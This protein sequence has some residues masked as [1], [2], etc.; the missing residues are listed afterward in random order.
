MSVG[1]SSRSYI[2]CKVNWPFCS[3]LARY[4]FFSLFNLESSKLQG[5]RVSTSEQQVTAHPKPLIMPPLSQEAAMKA[6]RGPVDDPKSA[7]G[8]HRILSPTAGVR[9]SPLCLGAMNFGEAWE[10][11]MG[12]CD[13]KDTFEMLDYFYDQGG[14][15]IDTAN[16]YQMEES[17]EWIGEWMEKRGVRDQIVIATKFTTNFKAG[18]GGDHPGQLSNH[19]GNSH[20]SLHMSLEASLK[21]L[22]T[23]YID[24][25]YIHWWDFTTSIEELMQSLNRMVQA[26]KILYLGV[27]DTPAWVVSRANQYARDH[28]MKQF[29][30]YQGL[31]SASNRDFERDILPMCQAEGMAMAPWGA[32]GRGNYKTEEQLNATKGEG[33]QMGGP[34][35]ADK[36]VSAVLE[37]LAKKKNTQMTSL[38]MAYVM[39]QSPNVYPIVGGRKIEH[40]KGNIEALSLRLTDEELQ[41]IEGAYG[42]GPGFPLSFLF[43]KTD[44]LNKLTAEHVG[45]TNAA[46][47]IQAVSRP[48]PILPE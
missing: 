42:W 3:P 34:S 15:F 29:S 23:D 25:L 38:A 14:N 19:S 2:H 48:A 37:K 36:K 26:G 35:E 39:H 8:R 46:N 10:V 32:L 43:P 5:S 28:G 9:V 30:V 21:K 1:R 24:V 44:G 7:L 40:L 18:K 45:L 22:R 13:K 27:S 33:R 41:E 20:K 17:E 47:R 16:N 12:K 31:W 4:K 6:L 11:F